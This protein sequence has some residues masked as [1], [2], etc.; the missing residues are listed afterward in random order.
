ME[1]AVAHMFRD[2]LHVRHVLFTKSSVITVEWLVTN[3]NWDDQGGRTTGE[4]LFFRVW[5]QNCH[6]SLASRSRVCKPLGASGVLSRCD[7]NPLILWSLDLFLTQWY[8]SRF[9]PSISV[10]LLFGEVLHNLQAWASD[11]SSTIKITRKITS[12]LLGCQNVLLLFFVWD[13]SVFVC[14]VFINVRIE[15]TPKLWLPLVLCL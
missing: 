1:A 11:S 7:L 2:G 5:R 6:S 9:P 4:S 13:G 12:T 3:H 15:S 10:S 14:L 8:R